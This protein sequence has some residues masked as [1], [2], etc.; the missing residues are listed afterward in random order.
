[1]QIVTI[2]PGAVIA[3]DDTI[4][5]EVSELAPRAGFSA[6]RNPASDEVLLLLA[7]SGEFT[8]ADRIFPFDAVCHAFIPAGTAYGLRNTGA[9][10]LRYIWALCPG[11]LREENVP[12]DRRGGPGGVTLLSISQYDR[13]PDSGFVRGG[14]FF[15]DG[16]QDP[17]GHSH[18]G[19]AEVF[20]FLNGQVDIIVEDRRE[21]VGVGQA[22]YVP[23]ELKHQF[24]NQSEE[25]IA[26]WLTATPNVRPSHTFY[27]QAAGG[28]WKRTTPAYS[29]NPMKGG[30]LA[31]S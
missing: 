6:R 19:A 21:R 26:M 20:V 22:V 30:R 13:F 25:R 9:M 16:D 8:T 14:M 27:E 28:G 10:P 1:M 5:M 17:P 18:D 7:G 4:H 29:G 11:G 2:E 31:E 15:L 12:H 23:A 24:E 3:H